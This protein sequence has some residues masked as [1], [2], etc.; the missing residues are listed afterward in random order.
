MTKSST[1]NVSRK[2]K[3]TYEGVSEDDDTVLV[4][5][6]VKKDDRKTDR[7]TSFQYDR[8]TCLVENC[9]S[10]S[11]RDPGKSFHKIPDI[12]D[13]RREIWCQRLKIDSSLIRPT[14]RICS[15]HFKQDSFSSVSRLEKGAIPEVA[16]S[17]LFGGTY[18]KIW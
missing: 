3:Q 13:E 14:S 6:S 11:L 10:D 1:G 16:F 7:N 18:R 5:T 15:R 12:Y 8:F 9:H 17:E 2:R 4:T